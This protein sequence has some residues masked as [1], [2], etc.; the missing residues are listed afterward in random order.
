MSRP[1]IV[2]VRK[3]A[4]T[5]SRTVGIRGSCHPDSSCPGVP[6]QEILRRAPQS[7]GQLLPTI[8]AACLQYVVL[9][10]YPPKSNSALCHL[11]DRII[12]FHFSLGSPNSE[13]HWEKKLQTLLQ[14]CRI[15]CGRGQGGCW[16]YTDQAENPSHPF[17]T[18]KLPNNHHYHPTLCVM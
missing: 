6:K 10:G 13:P 16:V 12:F 1:G 5:K 9:G 14:Q 3:S 15:Q 4:F 11:H 2:K 18:F 17:P 8:S 7:Q